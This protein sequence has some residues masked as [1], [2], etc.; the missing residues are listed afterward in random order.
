MCKPCVGTGLHTITQAEIATAAKTKKQ[1]DIRGSWYGFWPEE[2]SNAELRNS[3]CAGC[4]WATCPNHDHCGFGR[5][6]QRRV[7][8]G[9]MAPC[10]GLRRRKKK[11]KEESA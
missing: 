11:K 8:A 3:L 5:E 1:R 4:D 10:M 9:E 2:K 7:D 6:A